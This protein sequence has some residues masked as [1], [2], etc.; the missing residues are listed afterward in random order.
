MKKSSLNLKTVNMGVPG[1]NRKT[2]IIEEGG[3][4][5]VVDHSDPILNMLIHKLKIAREKRL[6]SDLVSI[7]AYITDR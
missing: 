4:M 6:K 3:K 1:L 5:R 7:S 2:T